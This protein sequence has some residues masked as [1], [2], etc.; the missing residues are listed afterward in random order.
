MNISVND[1]PQKVKEKPGSFVG[2][3]RNWKDGDKVEINLP[4]TLRLETM[5]D[6]S[7]RVAVFYG[8]LLLAGDLGPEDAENRFDPMFVPV[9]MTEIRN[10]NQWLEPVNGT[11][12]TFKTKNLGRPREFTMNPF[13]ATHNRS[14]SV[15]FDMFTENSWKEFQH[16]YLQKLEAK[17]KLEAA[18][19]DFF[20]PGEMQPE[21]NH[22]FKDLK[23][24]TGENKNRK[25]REVDR[26]GWFTCEMKVP[27]NKPA[28]LVVEYWGGYTGSKTFDI[29]VDN[30]KIATENISNKKPGEF[31]DV[32]YEIPVK[33][34]SGK[35]KITVKFLPHEGHRAGPVFGVR[36][37]TKEV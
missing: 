18:T 34:L 20:Q 1:K 15:Y 28:T 22:K 16:E 25:F 4:F 8:P 6:D 19:I 35:N 26:G 23:S 3:T 9:I 14:Y 27:S 21:R 30:T 29:L 32:T 33:L 36:T 2:I 7:N 37:V 24:R 31:I 13:Y 12:N 10:P 17:K 5:P 11:P